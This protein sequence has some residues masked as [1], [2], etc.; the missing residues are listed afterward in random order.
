MKVATSS[1]DRAL[2]ALQYNLPTFDRSPPGK[3]VSHFMYFN[4]VPAIEQII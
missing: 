2:T 3:L 4:H 1:G